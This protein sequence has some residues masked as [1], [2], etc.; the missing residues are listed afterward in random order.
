MIDHV[1]D[2]RM[3]NRMATLNRRVPSAVKRCDFPFRWA[4][5]NGT[6]VLFDEVTVNKRTIA[7]LGIRL[8]T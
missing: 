3:A 5:Q 6:A 1:H 4:N 8:G 2:T 7:A